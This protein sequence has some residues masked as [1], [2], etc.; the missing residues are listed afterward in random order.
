MDCERFRPSRVDGMPGIEEVAVFPDR[1][2]LHAGGE[3]HVFWF[4]RIARWP[5]PRGIW[6]LAFKLGVRPGWLPVANRDWC[7]PPSER[8]FEFYTEPRVKVYMPDGNNEG[9]DGARFQ[10]IKELMLAGG[11]HSCDLA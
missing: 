9:A 5:W 7:R 8:Y 3:V 10:R 4:A 6:K 2:E 11:F 1:L